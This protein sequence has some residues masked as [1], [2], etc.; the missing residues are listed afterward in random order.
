MFL[1]AV[2]D[3]L[4]FMALDLPSDITDSCEAPPLNLFH[5]EIMRKSDLNRKTLDTGKG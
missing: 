1:A 2:P 3:G 4:G 5:T